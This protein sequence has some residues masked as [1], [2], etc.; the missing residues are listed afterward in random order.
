V[1]AKTLANGRKAIDNGETAVQEART[2]F[3]REDYL[4]AIG[5]ARG[6]P[7]QLRAAT[8]DLETATASGG[9]RRR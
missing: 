3:D 1:P 5:T 9:R 4:A 7:A 2:A 6:V 8:H